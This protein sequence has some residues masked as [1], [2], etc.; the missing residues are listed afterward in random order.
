MIRTTP[1]IRS[2]P[3]FATSAGKATSLLLVAA[4]VAATAPVLPRGWEAATLLSGERDADAVA[5]YQ[6]KRLAPDDY[7]AAIRTAL[8][9]DDADL[10]DSLRALAQK[11]SV[12]LPDC[13]R[14]ADR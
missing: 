7:A 14:R 11:Q 2:K 12:P 3:R 10:A 5:S 1:A 8:A 9:A 6:L 4:L 13:A